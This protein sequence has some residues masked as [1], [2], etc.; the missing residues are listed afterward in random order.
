[1]YSIDINA[2]EKKGYVEGEATYES[3]FRSTDTNI[4]AYYYN[5]DKGRAEYGEPLWSTRVWF[6]TKNPY[7]YY[8]MRNNDEVDAAVNIESN[9]RIS[10]KFGVNRSSDSNVALYVAHEEEPSEIVELTGND[11][12]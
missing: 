10:F 4:Y 2:E 7:H 6:P 5:D 11:G 1:M 12:I 8:L 9:R 3:R